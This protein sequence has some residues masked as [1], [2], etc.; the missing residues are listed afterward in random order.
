MLATRRRDARA[1][2]VTVSDTGVGMTENVRRRIF[3]PLYTTKGSGGSGMGLTMSQGIVQEHSGRI[4]VE[5]A[6]GRGTVFRLVFPF[7][8]DHPAPVTPREAPASAE[9]GGLRLL[10]V[11]D[12][13]MVRTVTTKLLRLRGHEVE[14]ADGGPAALDVLAEGPPFDLVVTDLSMPEMSGRELA[15]GHPPAA[16]PGSRSSSSPATPTRRPTARTWRP[17][18]R[19]RSSSTP[20]TP[21]SAARTRARE[22][23][24]GTGKMTAPPA[25][26]RAGRGGCPG[27]ARPARALDP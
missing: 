1:A 17:S 23:R 26:V 9:P 27:V 8:T 13:P 12:E 22:R 11:D 18:S 3:E 4:E 14:E 16:T 10:V 21:P 7:A 2:E 5:S 19:S 25:G 6:P 24:L 20:S 15:S